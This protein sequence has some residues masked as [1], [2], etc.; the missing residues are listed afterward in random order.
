[1]T[2]RAGNL[3]LKASRSRTIE[4]KNTHFLPKLIGVR[5]EIASSLNSRVDRVILKSLQP[6]VRGPKPPG[7]MERLDGR[8]ASHLRHVVIEPGVALYA[9]GSVLIR[10]GRTQV[11][12]AATLEDGIRRLLAIQQLVLASAHQSESAHIHC[13]TS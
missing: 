9:M 2:A 7:L 13:R 4:G 1:M 6:A 8:D 11:I 3:D 10:S 12:C 5:A